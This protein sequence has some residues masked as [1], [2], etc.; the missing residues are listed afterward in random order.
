MKVTMKV[1]GRADMSVDLP[2]DGHEALS[3]IRAR[4]PCDFDDF[5]SDL[6]IHHVDE[7]DFLEQMHTLEVMSFEVE[8]DG[9]AASPAAGVLSQKGVSSDG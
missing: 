6:G 9:S 2:L 7:N 1:V 8:P 4:L 5:L 3:S